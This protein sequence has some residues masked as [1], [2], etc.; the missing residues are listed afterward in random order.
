M[1]KIDELIADFKFISPNDIGLFQGGVLLG[2]FFKVPRL[3][4]VSF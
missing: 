2:L 3:A 4:V 1:L